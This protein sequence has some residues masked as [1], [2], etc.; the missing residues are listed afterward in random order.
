M[1][2]KVSLWVALIFGVPLI[3]LVEVYSVGTSTP[4]LSAS[5]LWGHATLGL[6]IGTACAMCAQ[7]LKLSGRQI[8]WV[9][10]LLALGYSLVLICFTYRPSFFKMDAAF[11]SNAL[12]LD[13][14]S[15]LI[16]VTGAAFIGYVATR[17]RPEPQKAVNTLTRR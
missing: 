4:G 13:L 10:P 12:A 7:M 3:R 9:L 17:P 11:V 6:V 5:L 2:K 15:W 16:A 8:V 1:E 14:G